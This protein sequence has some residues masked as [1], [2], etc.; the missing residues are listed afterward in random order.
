MQELYLFLYV[1]WYIRNMRKPHPSLVAWV[2]RFYQKPDEYHGDDFAGPQLQGLVKDESIQFLREYL[3]ATS[4]PKD[5]CLY[6]NA[7]QA[8]IQLISQCFSTKINAGGYAAKLRA[9][10]STCLRLTVRKNPLKMHVIIAHL[11]RSICETGRGLGADSEQSFE[12]AHQDLC[13]ATIP[14]QRHE[15]PDLC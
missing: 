14:C 8:L 5:V 11:D 1:N 4:A 15:Q 7:M 9:F 10:K 6:F 2:Q 13:M 12:S 3:T